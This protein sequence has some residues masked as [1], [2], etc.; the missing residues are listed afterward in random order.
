MDNRQRI[1][2]FCADHAVKIKSLDYIP[3]GDSGD[4]SYWELCIY[5]TEN[6][7]E[8]Y[9]TSLGDTMDEG[10]EI[11]FNQIEDDM[12]NIQLILMR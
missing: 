6:R 9:D 7:T 12:S 10:I 11:M 5:L 2:S 4:I 1:E 3:C 8:T